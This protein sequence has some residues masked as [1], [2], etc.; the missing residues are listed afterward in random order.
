MRMPPPEMVSRT[1][2]AAT[3]AAEDDARPPNARL[4]VAR[5]AILAAIRET[6]LNELQFRG[7]HFNK[8]RSS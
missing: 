7:K 4:W 6:F 3:R 2:A 5:S 8:L 1:I